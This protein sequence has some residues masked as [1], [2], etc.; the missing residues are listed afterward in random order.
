MQNVNT[1][2]LLIALF[3]LIIKGQTIES[4]SELLSNKKEVI[5]RDDYDGLYLSR[6]LLLNDYIISHYSSKGL[7]KL[8]N[9]TSF[10]IRKKHTELISQN[11]LFDTKK[12]VIIK[13]LLSN[14]IILHKERE[15]GFRI[16]YHTPNILTTNQIIFKDNRKILKYININSDTVIWETV[17]PEVVYD[18]ND[19]LEDILLVNCKSK[20]YFIDKKSG[21]VL[22]SLMLGKLE[23]AY[24]LNSAIEIQGDYAYL[25]AEKNGVYCIDIKKRKVKWNGF[26]NTERAR[27]TMTMVFEKDTLFFGLYPHIYAVNKFTGEV[28][29]KSEEI[30]IHTAYIIVLH[31]KW[32]F[33]YEHFD[34]LNA[35][36]LCT[37]NRAT[38]KLAYKGFTS[39][40]FPPENANGDDS[41]APLNELDFY[42]ISW[43]RKTHGNLLIGTY[44][45]KLYCF[46]IKE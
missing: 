7:F 28:F 43:I 3:P 24:H 30:N 21:K 1:K 34:E 29:W 38:G 35:N 16:G 23:K 26:K 33:Y 42:A 32:I 14:K 37:L 9:D 12:R 40:D 13:N 4:I 27:T 2:L 45:D 8:T 6:P 46:E 18:F 22:D 11:V 41:E 15:N 20:F 44:L 25:W 5:F 31:P 10:L 39:E 36:F 17:F 19:Q